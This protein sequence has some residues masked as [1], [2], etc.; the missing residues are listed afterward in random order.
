MQEESA[1]KGIHA[2]GLV[3]ALCQSREHVAFTRRPQEIRPA[4]TGAI[5]RIQP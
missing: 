3:T 1:R 5:Y 4:L 2:C